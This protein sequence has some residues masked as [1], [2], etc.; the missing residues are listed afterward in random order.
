MWAYDDIRQADSPAGMLRVSCLSAPPLARLEIRDAALAAQLTSRCTRLGENRI[1]G[2]AVAKIVG[3]NTD[4][5]DGA[6][7]A[8]LSRGAWDLQRD[9]FYEGIAAYGYALGPVEQTGVAR[10]SSLQGLPEAIGARVTAV[11]PPCVTSGTPP[12]SSATT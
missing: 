3:R 8:R 1:G 6:G 11:L 9:A 7:V 2:G 10:V 5:L 4:V 12:R